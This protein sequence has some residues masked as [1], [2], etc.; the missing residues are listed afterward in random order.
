M[1][2]GEIIEEGTHDMLIQKGGWYTEQFERQQGEEIEGE[3]RI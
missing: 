1:D 2:N 3:V